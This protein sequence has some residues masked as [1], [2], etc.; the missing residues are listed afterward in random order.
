MVHH[1]N[2]VL[3]CMDEYDLLM[4]AV[5]YQINNVHVCHIVTNLQSMKCSLLTLSVLI[6]TIVEVI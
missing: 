6:T 4:M 5:M 2:K 1:T 3:E